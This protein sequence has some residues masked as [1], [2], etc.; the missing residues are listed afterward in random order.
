[1]ITLYIVKKRWQQ[2]LV[3]AAVRKLKLFCQLR[4]T[5]RVP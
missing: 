1:L 2:F 5:G 4:P 3:L